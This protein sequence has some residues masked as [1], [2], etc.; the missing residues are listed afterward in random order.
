MKFGLYEC[1]PVTME[2]K[3]RPSAEIFR[4]LAWNKMI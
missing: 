4:K 2:R 1:D 3:K